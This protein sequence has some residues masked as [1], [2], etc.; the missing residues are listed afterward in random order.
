MLLNHFIVTTHHMKLN[1]NIIHYGS[2]EDLLQKTALKA[3]NLNLFY[4]NGFIRYVKFGD[5]E[6]IRMINHAVR[7]YNWGTISLKLFDEKIDIKERSFSIHY[8]AEA[9]Q[10]GAHFLWKCKIEGRADSTIVFNI[11]GEA[12]TNF[13]RNRVGFTILH[14]IKECEG[15]EVKIRDSDENIKVQIFPRLISAAQ[16]FFNIKT[17]E[18]ELGG[19]KVL[20]EFKGDIFETE[21][22][23]NWIDASYKTYCT[24]LD[25][26]FPVELKK[27]DKVSQVIKLSIHG[28]SDLK[29]SKT[30]DITFSIEEKSFSIPKIGIAQSSEIDNL[31]T[32]EIRK[33]KAIPFDH[34]Q[35]DIKLFEN[36]WIE[37][38]KRA[39]K[40]S[41]FLEFPLELSL[42]FDA[43]E[44]ELKDF[45][46][47]VKNKKVHVTS[48]NVFNKANHVTQIETV[49]LVLPVLRNLFPNAIIGGGTNAFF[50]ELNRDR[51]SVNE[52]DFLVYSFNPQVHAFDNDSLVETIAAQPYTVQTAKEFSQK[53][54]IHISPITF[55]MRWNPNA[56]GKALISPEQLPPEVDVR[57]M[58]LLG[59]SW[60]LGTL[61]SLLSSEPASLT[62]FETV[63]LKGIMQAAKPLHPDQFFAS[64]GIVYPMY[65][66]FKI[67]MNHKSWDFYPIKTSQ[68]LLLTGLAFGKKRKEAS[69]LLLTNHSSNPISVQNTKRFSNGACITISDKN[70][71]QLMED[72]TIFYDLEEEALSTTIQIP[73]FGILMLKCQ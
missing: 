54:T 2:K 61:N 41:E 50:A 56:T 10:G 11:E 3:G 17:M 21:D 6:A 62:F 58:S 36:G 71:L 28:I 13:K 40:E 69:S 70:I 38:L 72:P 68:P 24:P 45:E 15:K 63:G 14:P 52:L 22:Q 7:D 73:P 29:Q 51:I 60:V 26:P 33:I 67:I 57:Q 31:S 25:L 27:G 1:K 4:E 32:S 49:K 18:W 12:L 20:L 19:S 9:K 55:K 46:T 43:I 34:Y 66:I 44:V 23:R 8:Q 59:A 47:A 35:V 37:K 16:P 65:F 30:N 48:I 53:K 5:L 39:I 64:A 42:F